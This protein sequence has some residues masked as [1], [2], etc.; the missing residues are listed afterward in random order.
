MTSLYKRCDTAMRFDCLQSCVAIE[1]RPLARVGCIAEGP[2]QTSLVFC[3]LWMEEIIAR[4][5]QSLCTIHGSSL[6][7]KL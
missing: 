4:R 3:S 1:V 6:K 7:G 5:Y 2:I